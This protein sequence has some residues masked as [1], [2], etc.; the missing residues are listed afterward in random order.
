MKVSY[1][2]SIPRPPRP[3]LDAAVADA[4]RLAGRFAGEIVYLY[5]LAR[6]RPWLPAALGGLAADARRRLDRSAD[7]HHLFSHAFLPYPRLSGL[8]RPLVYTLVSTL[9]SARRPPWL[10][11]LDGVERFLVSTEGDR[12]ALADW[13]LPVSRLDPAI[14]LERFRRRPPP[15]RPGFVLFCGSPPWNRRQFSTKGIDLLLEAAARVADL[16]LVLLWRGV[17]SEEIARRVAERGLGAKVRVLDR[18]VDV[19][20]VLAGVHAGVVLA[21]RPHLVKPYPH[22]LL[23]C[24]AVGRPILASAGLAIS[25]LV[26][27]GGGELVERHELEALLAALARLRERYR[28]HA[29]AAAALALERFSPAR[30]VAAHEEIYRA[31]AAGRR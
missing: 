24:L 25:E 27:G 26:G 19:D 5:P 10:G 3:E 18:T 21:R 30:F 20:R 13:G 12:Q 2:F 29:A 22:S 11:L 15:R 14:A 7:V 23:E 6:L 31:A 16:E 28:E 17:E 4:Q 1:L 9:R 8:G